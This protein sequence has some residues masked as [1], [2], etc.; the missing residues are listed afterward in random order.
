MKILC[1]LTGKGE[2]G[3]RDVMKGGKEGNGRQDGVDSWTVTGN[4]F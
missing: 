2:E 1:S 3:L 4:S